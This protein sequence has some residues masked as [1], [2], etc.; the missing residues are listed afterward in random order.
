MSVRLEMKNLSREIVF[1]LETLSF[2]I[3]T[4]PYDPS[5]K[6]LLAA[7]DAL[8]NERCL[9]RESGRE[10]QEAARIKRHDLRMVL[11]QQFTTSP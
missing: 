8:K 9:D 3:M 6:T 10:D 11:G 7:S 5:R 4:T 1:G 2:Y